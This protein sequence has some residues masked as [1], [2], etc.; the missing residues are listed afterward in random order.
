VTDLADE[1]RRI[2]PEAEPAYPGAELDFICETVE[3][4][5]PDAIFEWGT[6][7]GTSARIFWECCRLLGLA[8]EVHTVELPNELKLLDRAHP[9]DESGL[10]LVDTGVWQHR[11]D[12]VTEA[13]VQWQRMRPERSLFFLDGDHHWVMVYREITLIDRMAPDAVMLIHDAQ[14][15]PGYAAREWVRLNPASHALRSVSGREGICRLEPLG[16]T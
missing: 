2:F 8:T 14:A 4:M 10:H 12:G 16:A 15:G 6:Y 3:E 9:G 1:I 7:A 11:G 13:L 5:R